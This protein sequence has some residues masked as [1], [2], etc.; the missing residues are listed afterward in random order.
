MENRTN[1]FEQPEQ[2]KGSPV[3]TIH[4]VQTP[5]GV[6]QVV[7]ALVPGQPDPLAFSLNVFQEA[8]KAGAEDPLRAT[9]ER[10]REMARSGLT[11]PL[12]ASIELLKQMCA[13]GVL[14]PI[15][16]LLANSGFGAEEIA[17]L[18][19]GERGV[20]ES[21]SKRAWSAVLN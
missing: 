17:Q 10:L 1:K 12:K 14:E 4:A 15:D 11:E 18:L 16:V 8:V 19:G 20:L 2:P 3:K 21:V 13:A 6:F 7:L 9:L 5:F